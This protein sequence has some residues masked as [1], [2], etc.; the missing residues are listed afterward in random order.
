MT[1]PRIVLCP[2]VGID[3]NTDKMVYVSASRLAQLYGVPFEACVVFDVRHPNLSWRPSPR[4][5]LLHPIL[6]GKYELPE[7]ARGLV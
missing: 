6:A 5:V 2:G 3:W 7:A 1:R 4:D